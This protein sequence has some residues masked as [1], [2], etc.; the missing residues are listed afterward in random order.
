M[1]DTALTAR[2]GWFHAAASLLLGVIS[3]AALAV[4]FLLAV[5]IGL[6]A[7]GSS[8][9]GRRRDTEHRGI[10]TAALIMGGFAVVAGVLL[11]VFLLS[12]TTGVSGS[13]VPAP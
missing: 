7:V 12:A 10:H 1:A 6:A 4:N 5:P 13:S 9:V 8:L 11:A 3:V 2:T